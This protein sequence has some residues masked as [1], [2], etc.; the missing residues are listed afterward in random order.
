M[1][2]KNLTSG[3][4]MLGPNTKARL[5]AVILFLTECS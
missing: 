5:S 2:Y 3:L 4:R 1:T